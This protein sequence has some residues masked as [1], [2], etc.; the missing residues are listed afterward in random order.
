MKSIRKRRLAVIVVAVTLLVIGGEILIESFGAEESVRIIESSLSKATGFN[1]RVGSEFHLEIVPKLRFEATDVIV[2]ELEKPLAPL[3]KIATLHLE[4]DPWRLLFGVVEIDELDLRGSELTI[5]AGSDDA[6]GRPAARARVGE[7]T[8]HGVAFQLRRLGIEDLRIAYRNESTGAARVIEIAEASLEAEGFD[9]PVTVEAHGVIEEAEFEVDGEIGPIAQFFRSSNPY[10]VSLRARMR[11]MVVKLAGAVTQP[12]KFSGV[13]MRVQLES[14]D[15]G[16]LRPFVGS[17]LPVVGSTLPAAGWTLPAIDSVLLDAK[18]SDADGNL[19]LKGDIQVVARGGDITG[20][21]SG[22][23]GN[24]SRS[25]D[26][27]LQISAHANDLG[28]IGKSLL[29]EIKLP[30]VGPVDASVTIRGSASALS[31]RDFAVQVGSRDATWLKA[32]GS[33][34]DLVK[35]TGVQVSGE[36]FA[37]DLRV[38]SDYLGRDL[39]ALGPIKGSATLSDRDGSLGVE[40]LKITGGREGTLTFDFA[41]QVDRVRGLDEIGVDAKLEGKSLDIVGALFGI[42]LPSIGPVAFSGR[43]IGSGKKVES[44]GTLQIDQTTFV[45]EWSG[46]FPRG[47]RPRGRADFRSKHVRLADIGIEPRAE[48]EASEVAR[49]AATNWWSNTSQLPVELLNRLDANL[50]IH[51]DRVS[52]RAGLAIDA[53]RILIDLDGGRLEIPE[54]SVGYEQGNVRAKAF[55]DARDQVA[56][57]SL[58]LEVNDVNLSPVLAQ[59]KQTVVEAGVLDASIDLRSRGNHVVAIRSNLAGTVRLVARDGTLAGRYS[60]AF[61]RNFVRVAVP[62]ILSGKPPRFGCMV[63]EFGIDGGVAVARELMLESEKVSVVGAGTVDIGAD[64]FDLVLVPKVHQPGLVSVAAAVKVSGPLAAPIFSPQYSS[65]PMNAVRGLVSN[66]LA[67]SSA[68]IRAFRKSKAVEP[69]DNLRP[70]AAPGS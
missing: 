66:V 12:A 7:S 5:E 3:L 56:E 24:L 53:V 47:A 26:L 15:L 10:P 35:F 58:A 27:E 28:E 64:A 49:G 2:S 50:V 6:G 46:T 30:E 34:V 14:G 19:G 44:K 16:F 21:I 54:F 62:S 11:T 61:A 37:A 17:T 31:A 43:V 8:G 60:S 48:A 25:D 45:G 42:D 22:E 65:M 20:Q 51:A 39:P 70:V 40:A 41:G 52:G 55:V 9:E 36:F 67:P 1:V 32:A 13:D 29:R 4:L 68:L 23:L 18:L 38:A 33:V 69:C 63:A 57:Y 59:V